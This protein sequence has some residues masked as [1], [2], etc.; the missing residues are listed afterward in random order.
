MSLGGY[1]TINYTASY[2][3]TVAAAMALCGGASIKGL[4]GLNEVPLWIVHGTADKDVPLYCSQKV[5]DEMIQ[6]GDT[7]LL[8]FDKLRG[9]A[10]S[11]L[12]RIFYLEQTYDW[13][14]AHSLAD[15]VRQVNKDYTI[16]T[17]IMNTAY[18]DLVKDTA[19]RIIDSRPSKPTYLAKTEAK[20]Y[21]IK[22]G[23]TLGKIAARHHTT[24][25]SLCRLNG[26][27]KTDKLKIGRRIRVK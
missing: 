1:G 20:Y 15:S 3:E 22:K 11:K 16:S 27:K 19:L 8:L 13:L 5:V 24:V 18:N 23:D 4:C 10:H 21:V 26:M 17:A 6:C 2:P 7:S 12:A 25:N 9:E 14:F